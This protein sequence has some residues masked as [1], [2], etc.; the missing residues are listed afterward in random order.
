AGN[1]ISAIKV[2]F[3]LEDDGGSWDDGTI[4]RPKF[5]WDMKRI[6]SNVIIDNGG[7]TAHA[8]LFPHNVTETRDGLFFNGSQNSYLDSELISHS[9]LNDTGVL[10]NVWFTPSSNQTG[11]IFES[12][13]QSPSTANFRLGILQASTNLYRLFTNI[14]TNTP[15]NL[16]VDIY[17][18]KTFSLNE[19]RNVIVNINSNVIR[20]FIDGILVYTKTLPGTHTFYIPTNP[21]RY[22]VGELYKGEI[23]YITV[24]FESSTISDEI[25]YNFFRFGY[26]L[27]RSKELVDLTDP[28]NGLDLYLDVG[29]INK[30]IEAI[31]GHLYM[32][33]NSIKLRTY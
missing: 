18:S 8:D 31:D 23:S 33:S 2:K 10:F 16:F 20:I 11:T 22:K 32:K 4:L 7:H 24:N 1:K 30:A 12:R 25:I 6:V 14:T 29:N 17:T 3:Y 26:P 13:G 21:I 28:T 5:L 27:P 19:K 15:T 9:G